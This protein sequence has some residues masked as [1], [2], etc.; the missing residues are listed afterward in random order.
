LSGTLRLHS[1]VA[2]ELAAGCVLVASHDDDD[3]ASHDDVDWD[4]DC[5]SETIDFAHALLV[6]RNLERVTIAGPGKIDMNRRRRFGPKPIALRGCRFVTVRDVTIV[7][8]PNYCV[9]LGG[10]DDV[11]VDGVVIR[12]GYSDGIDAD[13]CRRV[14]ITNCDVEADDDA[15][16]LKTS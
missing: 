11:V 10:C 1:D 14:R 13:C 7:H 5:D 4:T 9:S 16:C 8:S 6:G 15:L 12:T 2:I 3:F